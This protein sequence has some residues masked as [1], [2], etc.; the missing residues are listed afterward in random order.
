MKWWTQPWSFWT[1][2]LK[3]HFE[4]WDDDC[5]PKDL[6]GDSRQIIIVWAQLGTWSVCVMKFGTQVQKTRR[7]SIDF[8]RHE[9]KEWA[10]KAGSGRKLFDNA[11][12]YMTCWLKR[13][14]ASS[15]LLIHKKLI[16]KTQDAVSFLSHFPCMESSRCLSFH[17]SSLYFL[18]S[19]LSMVLKIIEKQN[20]YFT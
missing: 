10:Y 8:K 15:L 1:H 6:D 16:K 12:C 13:K 7:D 17:F 5:L 3:S 20:L 11:T 4:R 2:N 18:F 19:F 9:D 14:G